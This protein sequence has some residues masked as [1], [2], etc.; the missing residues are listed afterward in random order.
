M[1]QRLFTSTMNRLVRRGA[2]G[3]TIVIMAIA[4]IVLLAFVGIV[5]DVS[6]L[7]VRYSTLRR[8]VDAAAVSAAGQIRRT[9]A[10]S[11]ELASAATQGGTQEQ[12]EAR[13]AGYA[14][15]RN[16]ATVNLAA[17]QFIEF[18]GLSPT[19]VLVNDCATMPA[20]DAA[21]LDNPA[22]QTRSDVVLYNELECDYR[23]QPRKLVKVTAQVD[24]PTVFLRLIGW[25]N[26]RLEAS[27]ISETAV[28]DVVM[29]F[30]A[31]ESMLNQTTY[32]D[33]EKVPSPVPGSTTLEVDTVNTINWGMRY[34]IPRMDTGTGAISPQ[35][36][37]AADP[38]GDLYYYSRAWT[39][40]L[41]KTNPQIVGEGRTNGTINPASFDAKVVVRPYIVDAGNNATVSTFSDSRNPRTE[42]RV[43]FYPAGQAIPMSNGTG[44]YVVT[45]DVYQE[46]TAI[47]GTAPTI[48]P[49]GST[50]TWQPYYDGFVPAY[51]YFGCCNDPNGDQNFDDL[52]CQPFRQ[53]RN[54]AEAFLDRIDFNRGD[55]VAF[56]TFDRDAFLVDPDG[57]AGSEVHMITRQDVAL[58][59]L[60]QIVGVRA[61]PNFYA[62]TNNNGQWDG[63][64]VGGAPFN[65]SDPTNSGKVYSYRYNQNAGSTEYNF[66][67]SQYT[68]PGGFD[69]RAIQNL[70][71]YPIKDNCFWTTAMLPWPL[72]IYSS[73]AN[74][75]A[76]GAEPNYIPFGDQTAARLGLRV[77][78][79]YPNPLAAQGVTTTLMHPNLND[80]SWEA[81]MT[82]PQ[83]S[84]QGNKPRFAYEVAG[85]C[86]G[87]NV[88]SALRQANNALLD[89]DTVRVNGAVWVMVML[90]DGAAAGS[91]PV[92]RGG[93]NGTLSRANP[94]SSTNAPPVSGDY[95]SYG[96][97]PYG[98]PTATGMG[99]LVG[100]GG[101]WESRPPRCMDEFPVSRHFCFNPYDN[102]DSAGAVYIDLNDSEECQNQYDVDDFARDWADFIGLSDPFPA[103]SVAD[104]GRN[105]LQLPTIFT[106]GFGLDFQQGDGSCTANINDCLGEE[107]LRYIADVGDNNR[108]D[109]DYQQDY[110]GTPSVDK[111]LAAGDSYGS[112]GPCEGVVL[113]GYADAEAIPASQIE[114][115]LINPLPPKQNCGNYFNAPDA[116]KLDSVFN[117][118]ASRMF[119]RLTR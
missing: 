116:A 94:Y 62:D 37:N 87:S 15:A 46:Q 85:G 39:T 115:L 4:F 104:P 105:A 64:V 52:I 50:G 69:G 18:Y 13:A 118:I 77:A 93:A 95:G 58:K 22:Y 117:E 43:R 17:R 65:A 1:K 76:N 114:T 54:S 16:V 99:E 29:I 32:N 96:L 98:L 57:S 48:A 91:D 74:E 41:S 53:V 59:A 68:T 20:L 51:N 3:Q 90:G 81:L 60:R 82:F 110:K 106:I 25:G 109:T 44:D 61:E 88:G 63:F 7:F 31:S 67:T 6:L 70:T 92:R 45:D 55:R 73:P 38:T 89:P 80:P 97:C 56:V 66:A 86:R 42:C 27:A 8:A 23:L 34:S 113:G 14:Y 35:Y 26:V 33:W 78:S 24:S 111:N 49:S 21:T 11:T 83:A 75:T 30:D 19:N 100:G 103:L 10:N 71:D 102:Q 119:T 28:I 12:I 2:P 72:S 36:Y 101:T 47:L 5:T 9:V 84:K 108:L 40:F 107:L 79:R 112:R